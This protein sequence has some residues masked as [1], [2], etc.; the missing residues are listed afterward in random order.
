MTPE[1]PK[2]LTPE[3]AAERLGVSPKTVRDWLREG[4]LPG[5]KLMGKLWRVSESDLADFIS[6]WKQRG[7]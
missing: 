4:K 3:Q 5:Y 7:Q 6:Q 1:A 2:L